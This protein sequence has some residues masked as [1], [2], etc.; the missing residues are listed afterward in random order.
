MDIKNQHVRKAP[1]LPDFHCD[2]Q[3]SPGLVLLDLLIHRPPL[4]HL[5]V[6]SGFCLNDNLVR[7]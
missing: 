4:S 2:Y 7:N 1:P 6:Q 5:H 3:S